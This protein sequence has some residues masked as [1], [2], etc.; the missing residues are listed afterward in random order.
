MN[1]EVKSTLKNNWLWLSLVVVAFIGVLVFAFNSPL[2][3]E[4]KVRERENAIQNLVLNYSISTSAEIEKIKQAYNIQ[5]S[6]IEQYMST[7]ILEGLIKGEVSN[8]YEIETPIFDVMTLVE[9][10]LGGILAAGVLIYIYREFNL[11][12]VILR[13]IREIK[14]EEVN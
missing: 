3:K 4:T 10:F 7:A 9:P 13:K 14:N 6:E 5:D 2:Y 8:Q 12:P 11:K 1:G